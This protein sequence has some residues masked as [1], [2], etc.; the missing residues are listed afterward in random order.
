MIKMA[1]RTHINV[2]QYTLFSHL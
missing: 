2:T 1:T